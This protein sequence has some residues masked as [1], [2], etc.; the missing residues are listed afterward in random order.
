MNK[1]DKYKSLCSAEGGSGTKEQKEELLKQMSDEEIDK[2]INWTQNLYGKIWVK[3]F[4][5]SK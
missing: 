4:K 5:K 1:V 3:S 2:I